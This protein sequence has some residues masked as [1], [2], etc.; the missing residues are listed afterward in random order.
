[1][2]P[3][4][5][6]EAAALHDVIRYVDQRP[7]ATD[8]ALAATGS[9]S[10]SAPVRSLPAPAWRPVAAGTASAAAASRDLPPALRSGALSVEVELPVVVGPILHRLSFGVP[11]PYRALAM[12]VEASGG[13]LHCSPRRRR[14]LATRCAGPA[15]C[16]HRGSGRRRG[17][18]SVS[19]LSRSV[20]HPPPPGLPAAPATQT[21]ARRTALRT[22]ESTGRVPEF[23]ADRPAYVGPRGRKLPQARN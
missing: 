16:R 11:A 9:P 13:H 8:A 23:G 22:C 4:T 20:L 10:P 21:R 2:H 14:S 17:W 5:S 3:A 15:S 6:G 7:G 19:A 12:V 1:V 18:R